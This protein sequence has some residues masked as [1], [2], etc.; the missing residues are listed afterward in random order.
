MHTGP[1]HQNLRK[2]IYRNLERYPHPNK[3]VK[4][5]DFAVYVAGFLGPAL[6]I[7]QLYLIY[8]T[9]QSAGIS[10]FTFGGL[11]LLNIPWVLYGII[12]KEPVIQTTYTLW[13]LVNSAI[14]IGAILYR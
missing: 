10:S 13:F 8:G 12:H 2:R 3:W 14:A 11:A 1:H 9:G 7:P 6:S 4:A 5:L